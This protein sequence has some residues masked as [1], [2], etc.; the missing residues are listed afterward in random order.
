[1]PNKLL[2]KMPGPILYSATKSGNFSNPS[3]SEAKCLSL[4]VLIT[5]IKDL[6][7][8]RVNQKRLDVQVHTPGLRK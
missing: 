4:K 5:N 1:M 6:L 2:V 7:R 3:T 8:I